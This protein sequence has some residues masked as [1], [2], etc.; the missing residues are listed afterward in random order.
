MAIETMIYR[1]ERKDLRP[2]LILHSIEFPM[3]PSASFCDRMLE[4][5]LQVIF[6]RRPGYG[7]TPGLPPI[8]MTQNHIDSG[9]AAVTEASVI[10]QL[11]L[12]LGLED[13]VFLG[14]GSANTI[15]FRLCGMCPAITHSIFSNPVFNPNTWEVF[16]PKWFGAVLK[17]S[18]V[19]RSSLRLASK[20]VRYFLRRDAI[21][22]FHQMFAK[23]VTDRAYLSENKIDFL[24][25][26]RL[27]IEANPELMRYELRLVLRDDPVL[28]DGLFS[29]LSV[30]ALSG[31]ETTAIWAREL[32]REANRL[33]L[34]VIKSKKGGMLVAYT[35]P[36]IVIDTIAKLEAA[37]SARRE[38]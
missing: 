21:A 31:R 11:I 26:A 27:M 28:R 2:L 15:G 10:N 8:L 33:G 29:S 5:G 7:Q 24:I 19:A 3:P 16:R 18:I 9:A 14:V 13:I 6:V 23:S 35:N 32:D 22:F 30:A 37:A 34:P 38:V 17:Q 36:D 4:S 25:A 20:G 1:P 12:K